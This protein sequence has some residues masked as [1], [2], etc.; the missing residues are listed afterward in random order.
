MRGDIKTFKVW[1]LGLFRRKADLVRVE[2]LSGESANF[3]LTIYNKGKL[4]TLIPLVVRDNSCRSSDTNPHG[5]EISFRVFSHHNLVP[6]SLDLDS[7]IKSLDSI[8][9]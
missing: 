1:R 9:D 8:V 7:Y 4:P 2:V 3:R 6:A 5:R